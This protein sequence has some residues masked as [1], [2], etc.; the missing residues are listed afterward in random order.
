MG[1][2]GHHIN[3]FMGTQDSQA[4]MDRISQSCNFD[5]DKTAVHLW[6]AEAWMRADVVNLRGLWAEMWTDCVVIL[7]AME[8]N[9]RSQQ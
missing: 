5:P 7:W 2:Y 8:T 6:V 9:M 3:I 4:G 1:E